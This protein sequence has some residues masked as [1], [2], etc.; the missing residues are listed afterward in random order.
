MKAILSCVHGNVEALQAVIADAARQRAHA[1]YNL[2]D[3]AGYGGPNPLECLDLAMGMMNV[4][5]LGNNDLAL[6]FDPDGYGPIAERGIL[7][8]R[9]VLESSLEDPAIRERHIRFVASLPR[10]HKEDDVLYVHGSPR[11]PLY[12]YMV[13]E[14][15]YNER[16]MTRLAA[17]FDQVCFAGHT[18]VPGIFV[19]RDVGRWDFVTPDDCSNRFVIEGRRV[20]CNV[21]SVGQPRD[22]DWRACYVLFDGACI[23]FRRVDYDVEA[24]IR[25]IHA[26]AELD[27]FFAERLRDGR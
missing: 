11:D 21:G 12:E 25:K 15:I 6:L 23:W 13:P 5:L 8:A 7:W 19:E 10:S 26:I 18:H 4:V 20:I 16:K 27:H 14:D 22:G 24:T 1:L 3:T 9:S 17:M 2:G